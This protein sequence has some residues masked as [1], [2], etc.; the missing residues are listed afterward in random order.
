MNFVMIKV[1]DT[2][3]Y[4]YSNGVVKSYKNQLC[5]GG[6]WYSLPIWK[7]LRMRFS[8]IPIIY[9]HTHNMLFTRIMRI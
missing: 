1:V 5:H 6:R 7:C 2:D 8:E 4:N 9:K 3:H